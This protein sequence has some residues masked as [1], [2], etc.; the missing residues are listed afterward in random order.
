MTILS[1]LTC[2]ACGSDAGFKPF[3]VREAMLG[4]GDHHDYGEC[5]NCGSV[6]NLC[7]PQDLGSYYPAHYYSLTPK[8]EHPLKSWL[9]TQRARHGLGAVNPLGAIATAFLGRPYF[10][11]WLKRAQAHHNTAILDVGCGSGALLWHLKACGYG[12]LTGVD[13]FLPHASEHPGL[14]LLKLDLGDVTGAFDLIMFHHSLEHVPHPLETLRQAARLL[15]PQG[16][17]LVRTPV[18]G[19]WAWQTY[20][21][22]WVQLDAPRHLWV[23][24]LAGMQHLVQRA[25][26]SLQA[27]Q[28]DS[29]RFQ[30]VGSEK[31]KQGQ[32]FNADAHSLFSRRQLQRFDQQARQLNADRQG[33][34]ACFWLQRSH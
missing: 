22:D 23:P 17:C 29:D 20:G 1:K 5:C 16:L 6:Q 30:I 9:R 25:G 24:S 19:T 13:P 27:T 10:V 33:D 26:L 32:S 31:I 2:L 8:A 34:Q 14:R 4:I 12:N 28:F 15:T 11:P 7:P 21:A 18:T 3:T